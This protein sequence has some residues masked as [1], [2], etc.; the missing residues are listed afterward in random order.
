MIYS[1]VENTKRAQSGVGCIINKRLVGGIRNWRSIT[2][3]LIKLEIE[4]ENEIYTIVTVVGPNEGD[5]K[6]EIVEFW[7]RLQ[8]EAEDCKGFLM[9]IGDWNGRVENSEKSEDRV[10]RFGEITRNNNGQKIIRL[11]YAK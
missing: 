10:G 6:K 5:A 3:R 9:L 11:L 4:I 1:G 2:D 8:E 7:S